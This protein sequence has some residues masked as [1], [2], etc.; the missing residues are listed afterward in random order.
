MNRFPQNS[1]LAVRSVAPAML[2]VSLS[3]PLLFLGRPGIVGA[4]LE[5]NRMLA[6]IPPLP[7]SLSDYVGIPAA[8]DHYVLDNFGMRNLLIRFNARLKYG[9]LGTS[10]TAKVLVG[11]DGWMFL[12]G[13]S[14]MLDY[15]GQRAVSEADL[16]RWRIVLEERR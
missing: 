5:E 9:V 8:F 13:R 14:N 11:K 7:A 16:R 10:P 1:I 6:K 12:K 2:L 4:D 15:A 3:I